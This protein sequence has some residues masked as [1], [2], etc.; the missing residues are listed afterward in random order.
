MPESSAALLHLR[1]FA[2]IIVAKA[3]C[4]N[5]TIRVFDFIRSFEF[6]DTAVFFFWGEC[7][8]MPKNRTGIYALVEIGWRMLI[9]FFCAR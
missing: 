1:A 4:A 6:A 8:I 2:L 3:R 5:Y 9:R 7:E